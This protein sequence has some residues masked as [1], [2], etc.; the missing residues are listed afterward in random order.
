MAQLAFWNPLQFFQK[1]Q[2]KIWG[3]GLGS[4][5]PISELCIEPDV[6]FA[7]SAGK[8]FI[9]IRLQKLFFNRKQQPLSNSLALKDNW[10]RRKIEN[11]AILLK[12]ALA[13]EGGA[14]EGGAETADP[15][16]A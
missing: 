5:D 14:G 16:A 6:V 7:S 4:E 12:G 9:P 13:A 15:E 10:K 11:L 3:N 8:Q 1:N 2:S